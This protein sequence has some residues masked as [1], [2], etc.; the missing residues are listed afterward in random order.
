MIKYLLIIQVWIVVHDIIKNN[1]NYY[2]QIELA[3]EWYAWI[4][5]DF[6]H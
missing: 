6:L 4:V 2:P 3:M 5:N 1:I